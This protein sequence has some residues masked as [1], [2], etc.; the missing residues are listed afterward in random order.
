MGDGRRSG[1]Y[2][3]GDTSDLQ[4]KKVEVWLHGRFADNHFYHEDTPYEFE[5]TGWGTSQVRLHLHTHIGAPKDITWSLQVDK[6]NASV[7]INFWV[8]HVCTL[9]STVFGVVSDAA[10][11]LDPGLRQMKD[12]RYRFRRCTATLS[13]VEG[14]ALRVAAYR[15][16]GPARRVGYKSESFRFKVHPLTQRPYGSGGIR[17]FLCV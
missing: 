7:R 11:A 13:S 17:S 12:Q 16:M 15:D 3:R 9:V 10:N 5:A 8:L 14:E 4:K 2:A 6:P 1:L